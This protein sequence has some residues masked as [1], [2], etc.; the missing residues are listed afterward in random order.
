MIT[1]YDYLDS[2]NGYKIRLALAQLEKETHDLEDAREIMMYLRHEA[3]HAFTY[4]YKLHNSPEWKKTFGPFRH[5]DLLSP[6]RPNIG[7]QG[8]PVNRSAD[9]IKH[10]K[11]KIV[12][13]R[14]A[15]VTDVPTGLNRPAA[16]A[17]EPIPSLASINAHASPIGPAP[18][19]ATDGEFIELGTKNHE[20]PSPP[21][22]PGIA[23]LRRA[24]PGPSA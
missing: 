13:R 12:H 16:F 14:F 18:M 9:A 10:G 4:A 11:K 17:G 6:R 1:L 23:R 24:T 22:S 20:G 2:G 21:A 5:L 3:G 8:L 15:I 19:M 7:P